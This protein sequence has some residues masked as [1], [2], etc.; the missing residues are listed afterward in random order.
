M[1]A[2]LIQPSGGKVAKEHYETSIR[3]KV[4]FSEHL[5]ALTSKELESLNSNFADGQA[6]MWGLVGGD[7]GINISRWDSINPG[8]IVLFSGKKKMFAMGTIVTKFQNAQ[9]AK[10]L[11]GKDSKGQTWEYMYTL[12]DVRD[13]DISYTDFNKA[14][15]DNPRNN[16]MGFRILKADKSERFIAYLEGVGGSFRDAGAAI[17]D[18]NEDDIYSVLDEWGTNSATEF[19]SQNNLNPAFKFVIINKGVPYDA[20]AV[21]DMALR[22]RFPKSKYS[23]D[24]NERTVARPLRALGFVV[25]DKNDSTRRYWWVNQNRT[26]E[27]A[28]EGFMWSPKTR[29]DG[30][31]NQ[32]Y[33]NM[34]RTKPGDVIF[35]FFDSRI[36]GHGT[37]TEYPTT[38]TKP[39]FRQ[40][41]SWSK[42]GWYVAVD[43]EKFEQPISPRLHAAELAPLLPEK[44]APIKKSGE[45][46][47]GVYLAEISEALA[48]KIFELSGKQLETSSLSRAT[49]RVQA[50]QKVIRRRLE[51]QWSEQRQEQEIQDSQHLGDTE[52]EVLTKSRRGQG[53]FRRNVLNRGPQCRVTGVREPH[54]IASHI[55]PWKDSSN[56][57]RIDGDNGLMLAPHIDHL[58]NDGFIS[59]TDDGNVLFSDA[60]EDAVLRRWNLDSLKNV[61]AFTPEQAF[62]LNFHRNQVFLGTDAPKKA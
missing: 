7:N 50:K 41:E 27:E 40:R 49:S 39:T 9:L 32:F 52:K 61:G 10:R 6:A 37:V 22:R 48:L 1:K 47:Q 3:R 8:D 11:W 44:Y 18:L 25:A 43:F 12:S 21:L 5:N 62:Y 55:K 2:V 42:N 34:A 30:G 45:G 15:G 16:H 17:R 59:F 26:K 29:S 13:T 33:E 23:Y 14:I 60:L 53:K 51:R 56:E 4:R 31:Y 28:E 36:Q 19:L 58:F 54:L 20:K 24:G 35:S 57:E 46:L 38:T